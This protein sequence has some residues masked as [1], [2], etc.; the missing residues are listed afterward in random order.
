MNFEKNL[1]PPVARSEKSSKWNSFRSDLDLP[2]DILDSADYEP[3][4]KEIIN[5]ARE[6][7]QEQAV[8]LSR[9]FQEAKI[10]L[11][12]KLPDFLV[13]I[14]EDKYVERFQAIVD[15]SLNAGQAAGQLFDALARG[16]LNPSPKNDQ[17]AVT[18][19]WREESRQRLEAFK[20]VRP[21]LSKS[22][23]LRSADLL[24]IVRFNEYPPERFEEQKA[25]GS[26]AQALVNNFHTAD[27]VNLIQEDVTNLIFP[28]QPDQPGYNSSESELY[29]HNP[30]SGQTLDCRL[31]LPENF[32]FLPFR[33][34]REFKLENNS[35]DQTAKPRLTFK[36]K[37]LH[38]YTGAE[39]SDGEFLM[40][41]LEEAVVYGNLA[42]P[43]AR[44][45]LLHEIAH[46][47]H[48]KYRDGH[49]KSNFIKFYDELNRGAA[50]INFSISGI[51]VAAPMIEWATEGNKPEIRQEAQR[52]MAEYQAYRDRGQAVL[53]NLSVTLVEP[54]EA[55]GESESSALEFELPIAMNT[56]KIRSDR[57]PSLI[58]GYVASERDAWAHA[59]RVLRFLRAQ[60][61]DLEPG[62]QS[63][64]DITEYIHH[65][66]ATYQADLD[67]RLKTPAKLKKFTIH[68]NKYLS[69]DPKQ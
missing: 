27:G 48:E 43:G 33:M 8:P 26:L 45:S 19:Y 28:D 6:I 63:P 17:P 39:T 24:G 65:C 22:E 41:P 18:S 2:D 42:K 30:A 52:A 64:E 49:A 68:K 11:A 4:L 58:G 32:R 14:W 15:K 57:L 69:K 12:E 31:L 37:D 56:L 10:Q 59:L 29:V 9:V 23:R 16:R 51:K 36:K 1:A 21:Y 66:L 60:G 35:G 34:L 67:S 25:D 44:L 5:K 13:R 62:L 40:Y 54:S 50:D 61:I 47:W 53:K 20:T 46:A 55:T 38:D 7:F 3:W